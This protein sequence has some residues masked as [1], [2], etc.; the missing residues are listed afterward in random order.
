MQDFL[1]RRMA[2]RLAE[3][4]VEKRA[5]AAKAAGEGG[6]GQAIAG[7]AANDLDR[8]QDERLAPPETARRFAA[9]RQKRFDSDFM[10]RGGLVARLGDCLGGKVSGQLVV[11][12]DARK[13]WAGCFAER[14]IAVNAK[15]RQFARDGAVA[16]P[17]RRGGFERRHVADREYGGVSG[18]RGKPADK[19]R[20]VS[21]F[22]FPFPWEAEK[23]LAGFG[24]KR[25]EGLFPPH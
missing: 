25:G 10:Q 20:L 11:N 23:G 13:G 4:A 18:K 22:R 8:F 16:E 5:R 15:E 6:D 19:P 17:R 3:A 9:Q 12:L 14:R 21:L 1:K 7:L 2:Y 24:R